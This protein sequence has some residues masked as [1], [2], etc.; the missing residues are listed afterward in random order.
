MR[1]SVWALT[2]A[3]ADGAPSKDSSEP[4]LLVGEDGVS[5]VVLSAAAEAAAVA[6]GASEGRHVGGNYARYT[7]VATLETTMGELLDLSDATAALITSQAAA[8]EEEREEK[9]RIALE[10]VRRNTVFSKAVLENYGEDEEERYASIEASF[11][12]S[13]LDNNGEIII[14]YTHTLYSPYTLPMHHAQHYR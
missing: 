14:H 5:V 3:S 8:V 4:A 10:E 6:V 1:L 13:D 12:A 2:D 11:H 9:E 7:L